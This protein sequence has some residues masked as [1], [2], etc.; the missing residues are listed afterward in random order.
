MR[1][2]A[3]QNARCWRMTSRDGNNFTSSSPLLLS[4][5]RK[6][7]Q[8]KPY[9]AHTSFHVPLMS[10]LRNLILRMKSQTFNR[11]FVYAW[12]ICFIYVVCYLFNADVKP[13]CS[14]LLWV[15]I[16]R[17]CCFSVKPS[18][19]WGPSSGWDKTTLLWVLSITYFSMGCDQ[20][21]RKLWHILSHKH[22][23]KYEEQKFAQTI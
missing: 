5:R 19:Q 12:N 9:M 10:D 1:S 4:Q 7:L 6:R 16:Q 22:M 11:V 8:L 13:N 20:S 23:Y 21:N 17:N 14:T 18:D 2:Y 3:C 15:S